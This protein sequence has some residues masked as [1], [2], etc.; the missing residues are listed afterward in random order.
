LHPLENAALP[1]R[2]PNSDIA[3]LWLFVGQRSADGWFGPSPCHRLP[4]QFL[5]SA[6]LMRN[7]SEQMEARMDDSDLAKE[8]R[9]KPHGE[10]D[11]NVDG[12][13]RR[14]MI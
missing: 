5:W 1:R 14:G 3:E 6:M 4:K 2:T 13:T 12:L 8:A 7:C 9:D 11:G 10:K